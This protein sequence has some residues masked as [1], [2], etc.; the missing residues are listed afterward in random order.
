MNV[1]QSAASH[2]TASY[3]MMSDSKMNQSM[4]SDNFYNGSKLRIKVAK[5][6][7]TKRVREAPSN[8]E[9]LKKT[10]KA[11]VCKDEKSLAL[12]LLMEK[13]MME[14]TYTDDVGDVI[15]VSDDEDLFVAY[16]VAESSM[17]NQIKFFVQ[18]R[19]KS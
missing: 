10:L 18:P 8:F 14:I 4:M 6:T 3:S 13:N 17:N 2:S 15:N 1:N 19:K 16:E 9:G 11:Q 5:D 7:V 12:F